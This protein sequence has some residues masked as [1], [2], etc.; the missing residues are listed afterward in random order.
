MMPDV[1]R[2]LPKL[3]SILTN[4]NRLSGDPALQRR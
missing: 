3:D 2:M 1:Q 4:L